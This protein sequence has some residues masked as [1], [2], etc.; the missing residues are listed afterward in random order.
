V[1]LDRDR[2]VT[3]FSLKFVTPKSMMR[4]RGLGGDQ[5][6]GLRAGKATAVVVALMFPLLL[7]ACSH[8]AKPVPP[9]VTLGFCGS[10]LQVKPDVVLVVCN[11]NDITARNLTWSGWGEPTATAKGSAVVNLCAFT[12]CANGNYVSVP[13][14]MAVSKIVHCSK[15]TRAYSTLRYV[16]PGGSPFRGMPS[17]AYSSANYQEFGT[18]PPANQTVSLTC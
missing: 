15:N 1:R 12:D 10:T 5:V 11:T 14:D 2:T 9:S 13:I 3:V 8:A 16:F 4:H 7:T 17:F 6:M 18:V